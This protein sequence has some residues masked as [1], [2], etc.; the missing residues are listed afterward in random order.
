MADPREGCGLG[1]EDPDLLG[2]GH[3]HHNQAFTL[4]WDHG[5]CRRRRGNHPRLMHSSSLVGLGNGASRE[6]L[7]GSHALP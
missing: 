2:G 4:Q 7:R 1:G 3:A 5:F 6:T